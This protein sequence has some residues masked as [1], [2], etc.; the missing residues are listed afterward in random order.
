MDKKITSF[1]ELHQDEIKPFIY[2]KT[3]YCPYPEDKKDCPYNEEKRKDCAHHNE[4]LGTIII[5][6]GNVKTELGRCI[7]GYINILEDSFT[8]I[9]EEFVEKED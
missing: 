6:I 5:S 3:S 8:P 9:P 7:N 2:D 4:S 1:Q